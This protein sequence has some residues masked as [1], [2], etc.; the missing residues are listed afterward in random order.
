MNGADILIKTAVE[1]G[2]EVCFT[3]PG[4]TEM[5]LVTAIDR[6]GGVRT[7]LGLF[8][9]VCTGAADG[10]G[11]LTGKPAMTI[12]H[13]GQGFANGISQLHNAARAH[14]P[15]VN[16]V[17]EH[18]TWHRGAGSPACMN[19]EALTSS[20]PGWQRTCKKAEAL[21]ADMADAVAAAGEGQIASLIVPQDYQTA[22]LAPAAI[23]RPQSSPG[24]VD[25]KAV[26]Q[27]RDVLRKMSS[28][29]MLLGGKA[30]RR[31]GVMAAAR[32][33]AKTG[34]ALFTESFPA[35]WDRGAGKPLLSRT[36]H[37]PGEE[38]RLPK[39]AG[40]VL[41]GMEEP[42]ALF[43]RVGRESRILTKEQERVSLAGP[44][45]DAAAALVALAD[46]LD[47]PGASRLPAGSMAELQRPALPEGAL[48]V[49]KV[50]R[51]VAAVQPEGAIVV[52]E[53]ITSSSAY[54]PVS[55]TAPP[56]TF[57]ALS[58][59]SLGW[60]LS[61]SVGAA[62]ACPDRPVIDLQG[63]GSAMY[64]IQ[65]LWTQAREGLNITTLIYSN[66][67]YHAMQLGLIRS[68]VTSPG[69]VTRAVIELSRPAIEW[70]KLAPSLGVPAVSV[71][72][73]E[74]LAHELRAALAEPGPHLIEMVLP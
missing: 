36:I 34:C 71:S 57:I 52:D 68:G 61:C 2:V 11:R 74:E 67:A 60:G 9:G 47:A 63:D 54:C 12:L 28:A 4:T 22:V 26:M 33:R 44:E 31:E 43:G 69:P 27:A 48:T 6:N 29:V 25:E 55:G 20:L 32:I 39:Y 53:S 50:C 72:T 15:L 65:A 14:T 35:C 58:G 41:A 21:S 42:V 1:A 62:V 18:P 40:V 16:V 45:Q 13:L 38:T 10:Y 64:T 56:H 3:N 5:P 66:R 37:A 49:E 70:V 8:E 59:G 51:T 24:A 19:I 23:S 73:A 30:L 7:V 17:G 46:A